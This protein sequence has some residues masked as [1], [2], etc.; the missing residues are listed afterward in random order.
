MSCDTGEPVS[1]PAL[2]GAG[3]DWSGGGRVNGMNRLP[4]RNA[5]A[6]TRKPCLHA[7]SSDCCVQPLVDDGDGVCPLDTRDARR[8]RL[9]RRRHAPG[10]VATSAPVAASSH[11]NAATGGPR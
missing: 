5:I 7:C 2:R 1:R 9:Q 3:I 8:R 4:M 11:D 10:A 6:S